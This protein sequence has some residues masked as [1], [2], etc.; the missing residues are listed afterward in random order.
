M[1]P[2]AVVL[3]AMQAG[4][5][6]PQVFLTHLSGLVR[7]AL[8]TRA[9]EI[10]VSQFAGLLNQR[11]VTIQLG[12]HWLVARGFVRQVDTLD[13][14]ITLAEPGVPNPQ[15]ATALEWEIQSLLEETAAYRSFYRRAI[16]NGLL[17]VS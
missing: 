8:R 14:S 9:G 13:G 15:L 6:E 5:D 2:S 3:F 17:S 16:P 11:E 1:Q 4:S 7:H 10:S 12:I